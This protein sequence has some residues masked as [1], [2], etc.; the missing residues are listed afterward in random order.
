V[1][2]QFRVNKVEME[3]R[4]RLRRDASIEVVAID[5]VVGEFF[6]DGSEVLE[7]RDIKLA[8]ALSVK[9]HGDGWKKITLVQAITML[10]GVNRPVSKA[11]QD[12]LIADA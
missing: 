5:P 8:A 1:R 3:L 6:L 7:A 11:I 2:F 9:L 4:L 10:L 12:L